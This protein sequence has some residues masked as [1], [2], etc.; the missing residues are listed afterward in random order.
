MTAPT[1]LACIAVV[2]REAPP[3]P[4]PSPSIGGDRQGAAPALRKGPHH[5]PTS[6]PADPDHALHAFHARGPPAL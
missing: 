1:R 2:R 6:S 3:A 4:L 5:Q